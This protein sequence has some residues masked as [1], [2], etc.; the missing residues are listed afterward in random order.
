MISGSKKK[1]HL[2][3][4]E[5]KHLKKEKEEPNSSNN[6]PKMFEESSK[7]I[8]LISTIIKSIC[9]NGGQA[10]FYNHLLVSSGKAFLDR[11][12]DHC[13]ILKRI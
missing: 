6:P 11:V 1:E 8:K 2:I 3:L 7:T 13:N 9:G 5:K 4:A 12:F 10:I